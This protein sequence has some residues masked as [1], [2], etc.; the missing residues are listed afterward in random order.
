MPKFTKIKNYL[1]ANLGLNFNPNQEGELYKKLANASVGFNFDSTDKFIDWVLSESLNVR[2]IE[3]LASYLTI[4]ETYFFRENK[5]LDYLEFEYLPRLINKR[6]NTRKKLKIWSAGCASGEEPYSIAILL[7]RIVPNLKNWDITILATDINPVFLEK[8]QKGIYTKWSFRGT[9]ESFKT[10]Y[11]SKD[12]DNKYHINHSVKKMVTFSYLNLAV[13][14]FPSTTNNTNAFD[15]IL[16]RNVLIYFSEEGIKN[17][18]SKFYKSLTKGG[19]FITSPVE[20][21]PLISQKL[22]RL[23]YK[24]VTIFNKGITVESRKKQTTITKK[25]SDQLRSYKS[26]TPERSD[27]QKNK[28][29]KTITSPTNNS[30][31][32]KTK[33]TTIPQ[34]TATNESSVAEVDYNEILTLFKAGVF[35]KVEEIIEPIIIGNQKNNITYILLLARTKAN[36]GKL[37]ESEKL[38]MQA[39]NL[40]KINEEAHYLMA[41]VL[42]EQGKMKEAKNS[43]NKTLFLNP[44]FALGHFMLGNLAMGNGTKSESKKHFNNAIISLNKLKAEELIAESDGL[45]AGRLLNI[46]KSMVGV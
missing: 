41:A 17:V 28:V 37:V 1:L 12:E 10:K 18:T 19:V 23:T 43:L 21:S 34:K 13:D 29:T 6:K 42:S 44:D 3:K 35:N 9:P 46:I 24:G 39:I 22:N 20:V 7:K 4:G 33:Q 15:I 14:S 38:C 11:F 2:Q 16:C 27:L 5:A 36:I 45:T 26:D 8:A 25:Q 31:S 30:P 40:D 32:K